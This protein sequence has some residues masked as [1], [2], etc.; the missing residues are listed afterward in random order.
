MWGRSRRTTRRGRW[1][2]KEREG[3]ADIGKRGGSRKE[4]T[5]MWRVGWRRCATI[6]VE[7]GTPAAARSRR[8]ARRRWQVSKIA[9]GRRA[10]RGARGLKHQL[11][12]ARR[13]QFGRAPRGARG[14]KPTG[15]ASSSPWPLSRPTWGAWIETP[16][17][18]PKL[19][20]RRSRPTWGAWIETPR[21]C[22]PCS[23]PC[24]APRGTRGLKP[25]PACRHGL[26]RRSRPTWGAWIET[27]TWTHG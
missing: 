17:C 12:P 22:T 20:L 2:C 6:C 16:R 4:I 7:F 13:F 1:W 14:L 19:D 21:R 3:E 18:S 27:T 8:T 5:P 23:R 10:P 24:R 11:F 25:R 15:T 26:P 9:G